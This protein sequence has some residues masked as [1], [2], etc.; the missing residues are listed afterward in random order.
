MV[1]RTHSRREPRTSV[2]SQ[3]FAVLST[4]WRDEA[5]IRSA[6]RE[7]RP[8]AVR[9]TRSSTRHQRPRRHARRR[10]RIHPDQARTGG[11]LTALPAPRRCPLRG[12]GGRR[13]GIRHVARS[14]WPD[15]S[16]RSSHQ[17]SERA[18]ASGCQVLPSRTP[19]ADAWRS[20]RRSG[21]ERRSGFIT[22][23]RRASGR[24]RR[25]GDAAPRRDPTVR[26]SSWSTTRRPCAA[27][28]EDVRNL[29][30]EV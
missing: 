27:L 19:R 24:S 22:V 2:L 8:R 30:Y 21:A 14:P 1:E 17:A 7:G 26:R 4:D 12:R 25:G 28:R 20:N 16:S 11:R 18:R 6:L 3:D 15:L 29:G 10:H 5:R 13:Y 23:Y 9:G